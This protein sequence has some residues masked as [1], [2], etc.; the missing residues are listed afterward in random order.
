MSESPEEAIVEVAFSTILNNHS[1][2]RFGL[3]VTAWTFFILF[4]FPG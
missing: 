2:G 3:G 4:L 1:G